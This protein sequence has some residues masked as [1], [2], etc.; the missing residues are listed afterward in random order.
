M[1]AVA[2]RWAVVALGLL[3]AVGVVYL[4]ATSRT[5][6][7][8]SATDAETTDE[9]AEPVAAD[10]SAT[11]DPAG[12]LTVD[13]STSDGDDPPAVEGPSPVGLVA[14]QGP[15]DQ[16][17]T[18]VSISWS[19]V[20]VGAHPD[21]S[22][23]PAGFA[24]GYDIERDGT[25]IGS[26]A[27][28]DQPW[29]DMAFRDAA[30]NSEAAANSGAATYRVRAVFNDG[31]GPWS[32]PVAVNLLPDDDIGSTFVVDDYTGS[33]VERAQQAVDDA[34]QAGGGVVLFDA[35]T[36]EFDDPLLITG[37]GVL[38]RGAGTDQTTIRPT[39]AGGDDSC[40][41]VTAVLLFRGGYEELDAA[42]ATE[43]A[44][45][46]DTISLTSATDLEV[47]DFVEV[48]G[49]R[50]QLPTYEYAEQGIAQD[51]STGRDLR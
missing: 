49:V 24:V 15:V 41:P 34:E 45:G 23:R 10:G 2:T 7:T 27:V 40:G 46:S 13:S 37:N 39:F 4:L 25:V 16:A 21:R 14:V 22:P 20:D 43:A 11:T 17:S 3:L 31:A 44:R 19:H 30:T 48:D 18:Y 50:G 6:S 38:L 42:V 29:D 26:T 12:E 8:S 51:P 28:D 1:T 33:D 32:E 36:Y 5:E 35:R 9:S 47:G